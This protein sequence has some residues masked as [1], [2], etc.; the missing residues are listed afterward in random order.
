MDTVPD[1]PYCVSMG[2]DA[3]SVRAVFNALEGIVDR[4]DPVKLAAVPAINIHVVGAS[5]S[6]WSL[7]GGRR[8]RFG[9]GFVDGATTL[10]TCDQAGLC[11]L[12]EEAATTDERGT[13]EVVGDRTALESLAAALQRPLSWLEVRGG[14]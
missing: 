14:R 6:R 13:V 3:L 7:V 12:L 9:E 10:I 5:P 4:G 1:V 11:Q 8:P 2:P